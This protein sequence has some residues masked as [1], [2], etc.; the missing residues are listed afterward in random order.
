MPLGNGQLKQKTSNW[1]LREGVC[2]WKAGWR[3]SFIC[4]QSFSSDDF[5]WICWDPSLTPRHSNTALTTASTVEVFMDLDVLQVGNPFVLIYRV[6]QIYFNIFHGD[7]LFLKIVWRFIQNKQIVCISD[8]LILYRS[9]I[10]H[11]SP[12]LNVSNCRNVLLRRASTKLHFEHRRSDHTTRLVHKRKLRPWWITL[13]RAVT[14]A[15]LQ[16]D[17]LPVHR[18]STKTQ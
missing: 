14:Q 12:L 1:L 13:K 18:Q 11:G 7:I 17:A 10:Q 9:S 5:G 6:L 3:V 16:I 2:R 4:L 8:L 15:V